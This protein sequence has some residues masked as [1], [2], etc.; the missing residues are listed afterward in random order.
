MTTALSEGQQAHRT[1]IE[2][3]EESVWVSSALLECEERSERKRRLEAATRAVLR[4]ESPCRKSKRSEAGGHDRRNVAR[5][6]GA[7]GAVHLTMEQ[8]MARMRH[9]RALQELSETEETNR[10]TLTR[11]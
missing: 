5:Q 6:E 4:H 9:S 11:R 3:S 1:A 7:R 2:G 10:R 8:S